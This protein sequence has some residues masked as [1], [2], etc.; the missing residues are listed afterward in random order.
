MFK[1]ILGFFIADLINSIEIKISCIYKETI[2]AEHG[3]DDPTM[4]FPIN[5]KI[6]NND[7]IVFINSAKKEV[8]TH[9]ITIKDMIHVDWGQSDQHNSLIFSENEYKTFLMANYTSIETIFE[10]G[11]DWIDGYHTRAKFKTTCN[12]VDNYLEFLQ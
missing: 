3:F 4:Y 1:I 5:L 6:I 11:F 9:V 10:D 12:I 8:N 7:R 2:F